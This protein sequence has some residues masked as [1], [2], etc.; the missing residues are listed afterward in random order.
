MVPSPDKRGRART[1][2]VDM[3]YLS[4]ADMA[5][6][7]FVDDG[8]HD[9]SGPRETWNDAEVM[10]TSGCITASRGVPKG[11]GMVSMH[12][13]PV[14]QVRRRLLSALAL[15]AALPQWLANAYQSHQA[16][17]PVR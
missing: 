5:V 13:E 4:P 3:T 16:G 8:F 11:E 14:D 6:A 2:V 7:I 9:M 1:S 10:M 17:P 15:A 12:I